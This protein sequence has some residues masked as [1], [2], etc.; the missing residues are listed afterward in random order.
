MSSTLT[1]DAIQA[2]LSQF[3]HD[4]YLY[5]GGFMR[6]VALAGGALVLLEI[7]L[8]FKR[9]WPRLLPWMV[10]LGATLVTLTTW[11]RGILLTN[12]RADVADAVLPTLMGILEFCL[13]ATLIPRR[14]PDGRDVTLYKNI[15]PWHLWPFFNAAHASLAVLL[16]LNRISMTDPIN[17][18]Q[19]N[20]RPLAAEYMSWMRGDVSGALIGVGVFFALGVITLIFVRLAQKPRRWPIFACTALALIPLFIYSMVVREANKQRQRTEEVVFSLKPNSP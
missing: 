15:E 17:D 19:P 10:A 3:P 13:F 12:S 6:S 9:Y 18:F 2:R 7:L 8:E 4:Q 20:L 14:S 16:V 11:G 1:V 5:I